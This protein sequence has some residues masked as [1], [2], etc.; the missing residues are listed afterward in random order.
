M[1]SWILLYL[2]WWSWICT[3]DSHEY[4]GLLEWECYQLWL[5]Q[6]GLVQH[7]GRETKH[8]S[9]YNSRDLLGVTIH[10]AEYAPNFVLWVRRVVEYKA[11]LF[12]ASAMYSREYRSI[13][14]L[15]SFRQQ[16]SCIYMRYLRTCERRVL[17]LLELTCQSAV[18]TR[19]PSLEVALAIF[20]FPLRPSQPS[21]A[22]WRHTFPLLS[23]HWLILLV[24]LLWL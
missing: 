12:T 8:R 14:S 5:Q 23:Q 1:S 24:Y 9:V 21:G 20:D 10:K 11:Y 13:L 19:K 15:A 22:I 7:T 16:H 2:L 4:A 6:S 18:K 3:G 17:G